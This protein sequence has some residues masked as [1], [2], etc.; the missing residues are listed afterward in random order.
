MR[1]LI[2]E[3]DAALAN[4]VRQG[5]QAEHYT[6]DVAAEG[7]QARAMGTEHDYDLV[8]LD[9]NLPKNDG[10]QILR[11]LRQNERLAHVPVVI[12]SSS[13]S[14]PLQAMAEQ[15]R[16]T[17]YVNKPPDLEGFLQIGQ[18]LKD[19]IEASRNCGHR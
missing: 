2:A 3:D 11:A 16:V 4:F 10:I 5:L 9:L 7:E 19:I 13:P 1:I 12:T 6:V 17:R 18:V 8:V 14:L 15:L